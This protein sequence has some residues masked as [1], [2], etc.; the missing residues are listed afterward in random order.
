VHVLHQRRF[1]R[2]QASLFLI[3][4]LLPCL[5]LI[6]LGVRL[7]AQE[8][9]LEVK[10]H[11]EEHRQLVI[12]VRQELLSILEKI[13]LQEVT[14]AISGVPGT[15]QPPVIFVGAFADGQLQLPWEENPNVRKFI[16]S[17]AESHFAEWIRKAETEELVAHSFALAV[18]HYRGAVD[19]ARQPAQQGYARL[20]LARALEKSGRHAESL[21][22]YQDVLAL[23]TDVV[24]ENGVPLALYA[25]PPL[26]A[27]GVRH[28]ESIELLRLASNGGHTLPPAALYL[29]RDL[30]GKLGAADVESRLVARI[31]NT[32]QGE[33]LQRDA[34][35]LMSLRE[36]REPVWISYGDPIWLVG[37]AP[38]VNGRG[39]LVIAVQAREILSQLNSPGRPVSMAAATDKSAEALG[40][41]FPDL[42]VVLPD[43]RERSGGGRQTFIAMALALVLAFMLLAGFLLWRDVQRDL[44]LADMRSQFVSSVTH[45]LR[46]PL[47]A[48]RMFT[49]TLRLDEEVDRDTRNEYL[50]TIL[51]ESERLSRLV[52]N[53]LDFGKIERGTKTY[54]FKPVRLDEVVDGAARALQHPLEQVGFILDMAVD[55]DLPAVAADSDALQQAVLNLLSNAM[56]YSGESRRITLRLN[57]E[58]GDAQIQ[59]VD[60]GIGIAADEQ[61]RVIER[62]YR[63]PIA[64]NQH[65]PGT[66]LGLTL[67]DYIA[68]AHG[69]RLEV[70]SSPGRG[71]TFTIRLPLNGRSPA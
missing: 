36:S 39:A 29:A 55:R 1:P 38:A 53:V 67:V 66:G 44:R 19:A 40:E 42:R 51:H 57:Q 65:V 54:H 70:Q 28:Q 23:P 11:D 27:T 13:K 4:I 49:E 37:V 9:Q 48:I 20:G 50:D 14:R 24:D 61:A 63:A 33:G 68:K 46:T 60:Q 6:A 47:T 69:G 59:V 45:E 31:Q 56:K 41:N 35:R 8:R 2:R 7:I 15:W 64:E 32:E 22:E 62:F 21:K 3:A 58:N 18:E 43:T 12:Q 30:A 5:V 71:S 26:I 34:S 52:D 25:A 10:R 16:E 17:T